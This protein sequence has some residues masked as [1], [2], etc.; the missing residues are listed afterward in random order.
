MC[1]RKMGKN[2]EKR[3]LQ[4]SRANVCLLLAFQEGGGEEIGIQSS[5][6]ISN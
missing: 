6:H 3:K 5:T 4:E 2:I 1:N